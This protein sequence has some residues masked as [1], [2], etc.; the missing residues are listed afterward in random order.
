[1]GA[2]RDGGA[3]RR[4]PGRAAAWAALGAVL[5]AGCASMPDGGDLRDVASTPRQDTQV[6]VFAMPPRDDAMPAE[7]VQGFLE[8]LTSDDQHY[9]TAR[10]YLTD[11]A[12]HKWRPERSTTVLEN[13]PSIELAHVTTGRENADSLT[14]SLTGTSVATV[15]GQQAYSP[16]AGDYSKP[17]HLVR[18]SKSGQWRIDGLP[19]GIVMARS[20]FQRN[21]LSVD[22]YYFASGNPSD[23]QPAAVADPVYVRERV[24]PMTQVVRSLLKGPTNWLGPV[25]RSSFPAGTA[26]RKGV[27][28]LTPDDQNRLT[29]PLDVKPKKVGT[30]ECA[31]MATQ[32]LFT[33][34][35]L[36]P[37]VDT[38]ELE[39]AD[40]T[41]LCTLG[42]NRA[43]SVA[44]HGAAKHPEYVYFLD[45]KHRLVRV[46]ADSGAT[47]PEPV[48]GALG[49]GVKPLGSVAVSRDEHTAAGVTTD[50]RS[51]Y[52]A[53]VASGGSLGQPVLVSGATAAA[54]GLTTPSWDSRGDLW[55]ADRN[56]ADP[57]LVVL[58]QAAGQPLEVRTPKLDGRIAA[59]RV[60]A[61]GTRIALVVEKDGRR[62]LLV[63]RIQRTVTKDG[64]P[65][66]V[67]VRDL[68]SVAPGLEDVRAMS[69]A[70]DSRLVMV[71]NEQGGLQQ[72]RY[73]QVDGSVPEG[74]APAALTGVKE[75]AAS[76]DDRTPLV[77][78]S[79]DGIV[80]LP[81]GAQWQKLVK[82]GSG[83]VYPG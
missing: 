78:Y 57:R 58:E 13:G 74:Q 45:D 53:S 73:V 39:A 63:G 7:I 47:T 19:Q 60:A 25:V 62:S 59:V 3:A 26:L 79:E 22:K 42:E 76:E 10:K 44:A 5:L 33:L 51:M 66:D 29:V 64:T 50:G 12:A 1:V 38:V 52:V 71:G 41:S 27:V 81:A 43:E 6:R 56:P 67:A 8:A 24:D 49:E 68:R 11:D 21:Y 37:T 32:I 28:S 31:E 80:R 83:P 17:V 70:G 40:G 72:M 16:A 15:D 82:A 48:P 20:D 9:D 35:N 23:G 14:Y 2:D 36:T 30:G 75:I 46:P 34:Q 65:P 18:D 55:V 4:G 77:A 54:D 61:D 69:W